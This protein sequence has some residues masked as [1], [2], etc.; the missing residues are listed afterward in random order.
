MHHDLS[1]PTILTTALHHI[2]HM[3]STI[4]THS[5]TYLQLLT[6]FLSRLRA[7]L[8]NLEDAKATILSQERSSSRG[9]SKELE[10]LMNAAKKGGPLHHVGLRGRLGDLATID[11]EFD[12]AIRYEL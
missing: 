3:R 12:V 4:L 5:T 9:R 1:V 11:P 2:L 8:S 7:A 10:M 6:L